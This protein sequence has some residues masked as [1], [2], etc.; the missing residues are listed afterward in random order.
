MQFADQH[1]SDILDSEAGYCDIQ[2]MFYQAVEN[3]AEL[4]V[5]HDSATHFFLII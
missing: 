5:E 1:A 2:F 3:V 4:L